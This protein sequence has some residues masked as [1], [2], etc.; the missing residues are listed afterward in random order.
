[1]FSLDD[2][3]NARG[4]N[5]PEFVYSNFPLSG[6]QCLLGFLFCEKSAVFWGL[7][8]LFTVARVFKSI[9]SVTTRNNILM[10]IDNILDYEGKIENHHYATRSFQWLMFCGVCL[11]GATYFF[12]IADANNLISDKYQD[13]ASCFL[14]VFFVGNIISFIYLLLSFKKKEKH[15]LKRVIALISNSI[16]LLL[17]LFIIYLTIID[18]IQS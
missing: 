13:I 11:I 2:L 12:S 4:I 5:I 14:V 15:S 7:I 17:Y 16:F 1:M 9:L 8:G 3:D 18:Y 10:G 6:S